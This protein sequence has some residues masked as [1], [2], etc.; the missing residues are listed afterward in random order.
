M[1]NEKAIGVFDSGVG[2]LTVLSSL[3]Q[4][5]PGEKYVYFGDTARV[6]Y[7]NKTP[8]TIIH[9]TRQIVEFLAG[10]NIKA[11]VVACNTVSS[12]GLEVIRDMI[13]IPVFE[14]ITPPARAALQASKNKKIGVI[15]TRRTITSEVYQK[16][17]TRGDSSVKVYACS[18]PLFVP[19]V[20][21]NILGTALTRQVIKY[22]LEDWKNNIDTL[23]LGCTHYPLLVPDFRS[24]FGRD[25]HIIDSAHQVAQEVHFFMKKKN[26]RRINR[27]GNVQYYIS[28]PAGEFLY[29]AR[30][31]LKHDI[32]KYCAR[33]DLAEK[34]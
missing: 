22:Y 20:E 9:Y 3:L 16:V 12:T 19:L 10:K 14:V 25:L 23:L 8:E 33:L 34:E 30:K 4:L 18:T 24:Y 15:G 13:D 26:M 11:L 28:D 31:I 5:L 27:S 29:F 17:L 6:P 7:G 32:S 1:S 21:E 2:G